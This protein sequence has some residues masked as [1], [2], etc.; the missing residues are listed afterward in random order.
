MSEFLE[1]R[2]LHGPAKHLRTNGVRGEDLLSMDVGALISAVG[3]TRFAAGRIVFTR[4]AFLG[5]L[6][7]LAGSQQMFF[8]P[9]KRFVSS[10]GWVCAVMSKTKT[11]YLR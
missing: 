8:S 6:P 4:D 2:D 11:R 9:A 5:A 7:K 3:L 10:V 1:Q